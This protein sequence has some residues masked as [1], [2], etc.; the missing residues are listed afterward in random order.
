MSAETSLAVY[1]RRVERLWSARQQ[2]AVVLSPREWKLVCDWHRRG[3]PLAVI[4]EALEEKPARGRRSRPP[5]SL[6]YF[7][8]A[9]E[10]GWSAIVEGRVG[11]E[12]PHPAAADAAPTPGGGSTAD[13]WR[14]WLDERRT[15]AETGQVARLVETL[16]EAHER[17]VEVGRLE[18]RLDDGLAAAAPP[19]LLARVE[20]EVEARM[21]RHEG[22]MPADRFRETA[23]RATLELLRRALGLPRSPSP[24]D[25][26]GSGP[27]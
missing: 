16:L 19:Q 22:S 21:A 8:A 6:S 27:E 10:D 7:S 24:P 5:R 4:R 11:A 12:G 3:I 25:R 13:R 23:R 15:A 20:R 2:R 18:R 26:R 17:G 14:R 9:V 1:A